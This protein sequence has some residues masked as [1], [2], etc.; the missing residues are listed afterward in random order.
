MWCLAHPCVPLEHLG[1]ISGSASYAGSSREGLSGQVPANACWHLDWVP[2]FQFCLPHSWLLQASESELV[3][4]S[5]CLSPFQIIMIILQ[6]N[7]PLAHLRNSKKST[8]GRRASTAMWPG[9]V[10]A[11]CSQD[12]QVTNSEGHAETKTNSEIT[13]ARQPHKEFTKQTKEGLNK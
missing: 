8:V 1:L 13:F 11:G 5:P 12:L 6:C 9:G 3:D 4:G 7:L 2:G 10:S